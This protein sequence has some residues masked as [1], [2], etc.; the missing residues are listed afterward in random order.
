MLEDTKQKTCNHKG[1]YSIFVVCKKAWKLQAFTLQISL[2]M[3][4]HVLAGGEVGFKIAHGSC[5]VSMFY[6][7]KKAQL[8][9]HVCLYSKS[10]TC[11]SSEMEPKVPTS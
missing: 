11:A 9:S 5:F 7:S 10:N 1:A 4:G 8:L 2:Y 6:P 3:Q